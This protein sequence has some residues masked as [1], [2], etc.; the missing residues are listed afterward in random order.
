ML[1]RNLPWG[2]L[3]IAVW[4][5]CCGIA[6]AQH[7][8]NPL[9]VKSGPPR[10]ER[11]DIQID[12]HFF[13]ERFEGKKSA[14][15]PVDRMIDGSHVTGT[16]DTT[17]TV[18]FQFIPNEKAAEFEVLVEGTTIARTCSERDPVKV[19]VLTTTRFRASNRLTFDSHGLHSPEPKTDVHTNICLMGITTNLRGLLNRIAIKRA[20]KVFYERRPYHQGRTEGEITETAISGLNDAIEQ[21]RKVVDMMIEQPF[22]RPFRGEHVAGRL[23]FATTTGDLFVRG[24]MKKPPAD[25]YKMPRLAK[26]CLFD[27]RV[28]DSLLDE[29]ADVDLAGRE[30]T[31]TQ[32]RDFLN[33]NFKGLFKGL[34]DQSI[35]EWHLLFAKD[36]PLKIRFEEGK[37]EILLAAE[38]LSIGGQEKGPITVRALYELDHTAK[39]VDALRRGKLQFAPVLRPSKLDYFSSIAD[40]FARP[41]ES[42]FTTEIDLRTVIADGAL[43][44]IEGYSVAHV[45]IDNGWLSLGIDRDSTPEPA[46]EPAKPKSSETPAAPAQ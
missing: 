34:D 37:V 30:F 8:E 36:D 16:A 46:A 43:R 33:T 39:G 1:G 41:F 24:W 26:D 45:R 40:T 28:H 6:A 12:S 20:T 7:D 15:K 29:L 19:R 21:R 23:E 22:L 31:N 17:A 5:L 44:Q 4:G 42:L 35:P 3:G 13:D 32:I 10:F 27:L 38:K 11:L 2:A 14:S 18:N 25:Y 9:D